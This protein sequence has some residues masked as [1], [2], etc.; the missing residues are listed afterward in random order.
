MMS[1][2]STYCPKL[3]NE[4]WKFGW[5]YTLY[6]KLNFFDYKIHSR[7]NDHEGVSIMLEKCNHLNKIQSAIIWMLIWN[8]Q[9]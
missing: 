7:K 6:I 5:S 4:Y 8:I 3:E 2:C 1:D 9:Q